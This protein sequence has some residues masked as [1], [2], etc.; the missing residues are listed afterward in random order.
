MVAFRA[1]GFLA[2]R[3]SIVG[4]S[5][6]DNIRAETLPIDRCKNPIGCSSLRFDGLS[7]RIWH[8]RLAFEILVE[9]VGGI[10]RKL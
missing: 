3:L 8:R 10:G 4:H 5:S 2:L 7:C 9:G 6:I 1:I